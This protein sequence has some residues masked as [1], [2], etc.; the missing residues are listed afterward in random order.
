MTMKFRFIIITF[1]SLSVISCSEEKTNEKKVE[2]ETPA[3][4]D[5]EPSP[6]K[7]IDFSFPEIIT[8]SNLAADFIP[9]GWK[10]LDSVTGDLNKDL[11]PDHA[12]I[13]E[14]KDSVWFVREDRMSYNDTLFTKPRMLVILYR[15]NIGFQLIAQNNF[16]IPTHDG[17]YMEDPYESMSIKR[18][19][20]QFDF[21][22]FYNMGSWSVDHF[23]YKFREQDK[24][25]TLIGSEVSSF[26]R[27]T[28]DFE[29]YSY[30]FLTK[31][32]S[33][34]TGNDNTPEIN[35]TE[36]KN[37][38]INENEIPEL[39]NIPF[40]YTYQETIPCDYETSHWENAT[41]NDKPFLQLEKTFPLIENADFEQTE[42]HG[43]GSPFD[44]LD[45]EFKY[46]SIIIFKY[47]NKKYISNGHMHLLTEFEMKGNSL[48]LDNGK[49]ILNEK[50]T[51][52]QFSDYFLDAVQLA[53]RESKVDPD[54]DAKINLY[55]KCGYDDHWILNFKD[56][57]LFSV[58]L[59]WLL[60]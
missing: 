43:C 27:N 5:P 12:F 3:A 41:L 1:F 37:I 46:D 20:L 50:T 11:I 59:W 18:N 23:R 44:W 10:I 14:K 17:A 48:Y 39:G 22:Y 34:K 53:E 42:D 24:K 26:M 25:L 13:F 28:F 54:G 38:N 19:I 36:W 35:K 29:E 47:G 2:E 51:L 32:M 60:C 6:E 45:K 8:K 33:I 57:K 30:N 58:K 4:M 9:E 16:F 7:I 40:L 21:H 15:S 52:E 55:F 31:K 49:I 56:G